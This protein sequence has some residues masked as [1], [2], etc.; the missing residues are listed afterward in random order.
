VEE[1]ARKDGGALL[2]WGE[3]ERERRTRACSRSACKASIVCSSV[4]HILFR[5]PMQTVRI[6]YLKKKEKRLEESK[7][8]ATVFSFWLS[9]PPYSTIG[10]SA[11]FT[12]LC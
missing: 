12:T 6:F 1:R 2:R 4:I 9:H 3:R 8:V 10:L 7:P 5:K 11:Y